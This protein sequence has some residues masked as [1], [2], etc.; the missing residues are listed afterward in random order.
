MKVHKSLT[1]ALLG[2]GKMGKEVEKAAV[3]RGHK[4]QLTIDSEDE[5]RKKGKLLKKCDVA[6]EFTAPPIVTGNIRKCIDLGVPVVTGTTGWYNL[7]GEIT[8]YC[9]AANGT[10]FYASNFSVGVNIFFTINRKLAQ[11]MNEYPLYEVSMEEIH[12]TQ[13]ADAPSGTAITLA[14]GIIANVDR[15]KSWGNQP[16]DDLEKLFIRSVREGSVPGTHIVSWESGI[17]KIEIKHE[18]KGRKGFAVGAI[19]AAEFVYNKKGIYGMNDL[20]ALQ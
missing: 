10:L 3:E 1:I 9:N 16:A 19:M 6:V 17:D 20:L 2:Y 7:L 11:I 15:K 13:K 4:V 8:S 12:H 5:W 14:E 18:A